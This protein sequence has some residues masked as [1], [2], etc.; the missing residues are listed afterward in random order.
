M[1]VRIVKLYD[2][3]WKVETRRWW[4]FWWEWEGNFSHET[5]ALVHAELLKRPFTVEIV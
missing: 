2:G 1:R 3:R 5:E 4:Q